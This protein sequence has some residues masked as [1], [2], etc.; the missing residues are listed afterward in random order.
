MTKTKIIPPGKMKTKPE[1]LPALLEKFEKAHVAE[2]KKN[3]D[4]GGLEYLLLNVDENMWIADGEFFPDRS[5]MATRLTTDRAEA[6]AYLRFEALD[7][8]VMACNLDLDQLNQP[9]R[10]ADMIKAKMGLL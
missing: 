7:Q 5:F 6:K 4:T 2:L 8:F 3:P 10:L 1:D 9:I